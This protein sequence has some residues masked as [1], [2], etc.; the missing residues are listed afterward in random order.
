MKAQKSFISASTKFRLLHC[1]DQKCPAQMT[2][3]PVSVSAKSQLHLFP[4]PSEP[5]GVEAGVL[6]VVQ[7]QVCSAS[8]MCVHLGDEVSLL[9]RLFIY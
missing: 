3:M 1:I 8:V 9:H 4:V 2:A 7:R 6:A 5:E